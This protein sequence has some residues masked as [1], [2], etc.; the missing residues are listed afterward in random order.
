MQS[1]IIPILAALA[2]VASA[3]IAYASV[4]K[5]TKELDRAELTVVNKRTG[6]TTTLPRNYSPAAVE[7]LLE[8]AT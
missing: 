4:R 6:K 8:V 5:A 7:R 3:G 1:V 2:S